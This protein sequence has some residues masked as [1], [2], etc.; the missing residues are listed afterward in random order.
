MWIL[1]IS[2]FSSFGFCFKCFEIFWLMF[3]CLGS[4]C[5]LSWLTYFYHCVMP[6]YVPG[7]CLCPAVYLVILWLLMFSF[8][9][10]RVIYLFIPV[11][12]QFASTVISEMSFLQIVW[13]W[14]IVV[15]YPLWQS[16]LDDVFRPFAF[17]LVSDIL[18]LKCAFIF[19]VSYFP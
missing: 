13:S 5:L 8:G 16:L 14:L 9:S 10:I 11:Y 3:T 18:G 15:F 1:K 2:S 19:F 4:L 12:F 17:N 6:L 7:N